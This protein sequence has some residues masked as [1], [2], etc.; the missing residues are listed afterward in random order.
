VFSVDGTSGRLFEIDDSLSGSLFSVNTVSGLP[1]IEAFSDNRVNIGKYNQ[2]A[3]RVSGSFAFM[4][5][6]LFGTS[7][8]AVSASY[9]YTASSAI[10]ASYSFTASSA[11][12][13]SFAQTASFVRNAVSSSYA[14]TASS[15]ISASY[16]FT[17]SSAVNATNAL[18]ASSFT[19][20]G[21]LNF[22]G[23]LTD[24]NTV[25]STIVGTNNV[26]AQ[27]TGSY[28]SGFFKY[29]AING[30]NA[31]TGEVMVAWN[32]ANIVFTDFATTDIGATNDV[33]MSAALAGGTVQFNAITQGSGWNIR[34]I[35]TYM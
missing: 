19:I 5:G 17:A 24:Y 26:F 18:S 31:R 4:T 12:S 22:D 8:Q 10:S 3:I 11:I 7:S 35:G 20:T 28:R 29:T 25:A 6:S 13:A 23:T 1:V 30:T 21:T 32:G 16:A 2:E 33:T 27:S 14:F 15:A 9:A 34:S